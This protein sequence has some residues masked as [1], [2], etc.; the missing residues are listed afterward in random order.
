MNEWVEK[1]SYVAQQIIE[2]GRHALESGNIA[3]AEESIMEAIA[4][5]DMA[6]AEAP[7][8]IEI[9]K[10]KARA[11]N[12]LGFIFHRTERL[13][14]ALELHEETLKLCIKMTEEGEEFRVNTA[15]CHINIASVLGGLE[16]SKIARTHS[17]K[18]IELANELIEAGQEVV[19]AK[20]IAL[21]AYFNISVNDAK[22]KH[23]EEALHELNQGLEH[24]PFL[25]EHEASGID[26]Q[27]AQACQQISVL[28]FESDHFDDALKVGERALNFSEKAYEKL[29]ESSLP[30]YLTSQMNL[31]SYYEKT[32]AYGDAEDCLWKAVD[33]IGNHPQILE[34][35]QA[36]YETCR[37]QADAR[38][39]AG[40]LPREEVNEGLIE[41]KERLASLPKDAESNPIETT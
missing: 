3:G 34:R 4:I 2:M 16:K 41:V 18:A 13:D 32:T 31:I 36:F 24:I 23:F 35:G 20:N 12:E 30:V 27:G 14:R 26:I 10:I 37:N 19:Q 6:S 25:R 15:A 9:L 22:A 28:L 11:N 21:G 7:D 38:L 29:G 39:E 5:V 33:M 40:G 1:Q 17:E 8:S